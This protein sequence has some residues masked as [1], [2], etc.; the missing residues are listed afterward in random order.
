MTLDISVVLLFICVRYRYRLIVVFLNNKND[1]RM[2]NKIK[3]N[4][5]RTSIFNPRIED[6][7]S[8]DILI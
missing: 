4:G 3:D 1:Y 6:Y 5:C 2:L 7:E 8:Y